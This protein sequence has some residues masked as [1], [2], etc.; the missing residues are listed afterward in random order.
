MRLV[1]V[2][3]LLALPA[4]AE[5][6]GPVERM[7]LAHRLAAA[8]ADQRDGLSQLAGARLATGITLQR[9]DLKAEIEGKGKAEPQPLPDATALQA[10]AQKAVENDE[11]LGILMAGS[12]ASLA[13][14]PKAA[15][16]AQTG[17]LAPGQTHRYRLPV[18]GS[19]QV[20]LG[21]IASAPITLEVATETGIL[22]K[23]ADMCRVSLPESGFLA[24]TLTSEAGASYQLLTN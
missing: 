3:S 9:L 5:A 16:R 21:L 20:E 7:V 4:Q 22:C 14:L 24:V 19:A 17:A 11:T 6:P 12:E 23:G 15:V 13:Q 18:D 2:L 8:G 10:A 1:F